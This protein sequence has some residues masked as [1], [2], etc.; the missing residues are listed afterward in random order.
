MTDLPALPLFYESRT[1]LLSKHIKNFHLSSLG[2]TDWENTYM[3]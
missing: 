2:I 1:L 3:G